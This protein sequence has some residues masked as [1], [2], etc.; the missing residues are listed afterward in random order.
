MIAVT[1]AAGFVG[2]AVCGVATDRGIPTRALIRDEHP[3]AGS[4]SVAVG[5]L[6][7]GL[8]RF[9]L[10]GT[11]AVIHVAAR[12]HILHESVA[13]PEAAYHR[14]NCEA[15]L[16]V[17]RAAVAAQVNRMVFVST[18]K[19][20]GESTADHPFAP[21][22]PPQPADPYARSKAAAEAQLK[23][24]AARSGM[25]LIIIRPPLVYGP[26][27][28]GNLA[29]LIR[30]V[31]R[32]VPLPLGAIR[33]R[34]SMVEVS[35]LAELLLCAASVPMPPR[36]VY[37]AADHTPMSTPQLIRAIAQ[38]LGKPARLFSV[39]GSVLRGVGRLAGRTATFER[40]QSSLEVDA[41]DAERDFPW[42]AVHDSTDGVA[43]MA[44][45][46]L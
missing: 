16:Q 40:L 45:A 43:R 13:H 2:T 11:N 37:H 33:N 34:R 32:G 19:V 24:F 5:D 14:A 38:G 28:R 1:G 42:R 26:G 36:S 3:E 29:T 4:E 27:V 10:E 41:T 7:D 44:A 35:A 46:A 23:S 15:A 39:P 20:L 12:A 6:A 21:N 22:D 8:P 25:E 31:S 18:I 9:A 17:A 30:L